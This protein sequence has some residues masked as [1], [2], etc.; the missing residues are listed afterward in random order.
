M[1]QYCLPIGINEANCYII[2]DEKSKEAI[3]ID[4]GGFDDNLTHV[5]SNVMMFIR[6]KYI[7]LTHGHYDHIMGVYDLQRF[8]DSQTGINKMDALCLADDFKSGAV[9]IA[10]GMQ[11]QTN[12]DF[13]LEDNMEI[14]AGNLVLKVI[15]TPGHTMGS[16]CFLC[17]KERKIFSGDT[18]FYHTIGRTDLLGGSM[19]DMRESLNKLVKLEGDYYIFP[20]HGRST[21]LEEERKHNRYLRKN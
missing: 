16:V 8:T 3:V 15:C 6:V 11:K 7:L 18:L 19:T 10:P 2:A 1:T 14:S 9:N 12:C 13:F 17:E 5:I 21:T 20:G 4:P